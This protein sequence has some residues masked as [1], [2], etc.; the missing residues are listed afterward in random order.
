M[1]GG[2]IKGVSFFLGPL[3]AECVIGTGAALEKGACTIQG[4]RNCIEALWK[5]LEGELTLHRIRYA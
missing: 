5:M 3:T 4:I 1:G 2:G